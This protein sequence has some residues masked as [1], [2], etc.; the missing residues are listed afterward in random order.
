MDDKSD[1]AWSIWFSIFLVGVAALL[2][3]D[4]GSAA[5]KGAEVGSGFLPKI[6]AVSLFLLSGLNLFFALR[7]DPEIAFAPSGSVQ[8]AFALFL[9]ILGVVVFQQ[10]GMVVALFF[11]FF[12]VFSLFEHRLSVKNLLISVAVAAAVHGFFIGGLGIFD[13]AGQ[14]VDLRW[15][16]PW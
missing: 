11:L 3:S 2:F 7:Q 6:A 10:L 15:I 13:P 9:G 14:L 5:F 12:A 1:Q 16:T 4:A 8:V